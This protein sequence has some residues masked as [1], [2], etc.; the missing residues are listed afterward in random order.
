MHEPTIEGSN[1]QA[2]C[3]LFHAM[4]DFYPLGLVIVVIIHLNERHG[5]TGLK[6]FVILMHGKNM[7]SFVGRSHNN[8]GLP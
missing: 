8:L 2:H 6:Q 5:D 1:V 4:V 3:H 7:W